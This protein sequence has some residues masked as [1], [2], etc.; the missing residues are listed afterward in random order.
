MSVANGTSKTGLSS[1]IQKSGDVSHIK[2]GDKHLLFGMPGVGK[3]TVASQADSPLFVDYDR[4]IKQLRVDRVPGPSTWLDAMGLFREIATE[5]HAYKTLV[6]DTVDPL[7]ELAVQHVCRVGHKASLGDFGFGE[8]YA[9]LKNEWRTMLS[10][11]DAVADRGIT[12]CLLAHSVVRQTSDPQLGPYE[13]YTTGLQ[14]G[15]WAVTA[16]WCDMIGFCA[17]EAARI[18]KEK[19]S[20]YTGQR[21]LLTTAGS[22]FVAKN[23]WGLPRTL[24]LSWSALQEAIQRFQM[25]AEDVIARIHAMAKGSAFEAPAAAFIADAQ[26]DIRRLLQVEDA[27]KEKI[28]EVAKEAAEAAKGGTITA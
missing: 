4:G 7:E 24:P 1:R 23:R 28:A 5:K 14:K 25:K 19:R 20:V 18:E 2:T 22:G 27:L 11:L 17:F 16:R 9:A 3:S 12:V 21:V 8:G 6:I 15:D 10:I 13:V 26:G